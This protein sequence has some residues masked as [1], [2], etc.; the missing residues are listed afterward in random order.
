MTDDTPR[1]MRPALI[2]IAAASAFA[3]VFAWGVYALLQAA[4]PEGGTIGFAFLLVLPAAISAFVAYVADPWKTRTHRAYL[5]IPLWL[6]GAVVLLSLVVLR[7]G[8]IC[9]VLLAPLWLVSGMLGAEVA[10]RVRRRVRDART[11]S[12]AMLALPLIAIQVEPY[13]PLPVATVT[14][15]RSVVVRATPARLWPMLQGIPDVRPG[16]GGWNLTQDVLGVPRPIGARLV[17]TGVGADRHARWQHGVRFR[18]RVMQWQP[19]RRLGWR[20]IFDDMTGWGYTDRHLLPDSTYFRVASGGYTADPLAP[21]LTSVTLHT[22]YRVRTPVNAYAAL[23][24][25]MFLGDL[26]NKLLTVIRDRAERR[27]SVD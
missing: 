15:T 5:T 4:R 27:D 3:L 21:G 18:E 11:Y 20:F 10:Y 19:Q 26:E 2:R 24:G 6:L 22:T 25:E 8:V 14:V 7:E 17:G 9:V 13:V 23:W 1:P 12:V 16:E